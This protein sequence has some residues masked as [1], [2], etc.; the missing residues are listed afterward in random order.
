MKGIWPDGSRA[1]RRG[2][3]RRHWKCWRISWMGSGTWLVSKSPTEI[4]NLPT[5]FWRMESVRLVTLGS[6]RILIRDKTQLWGPLWARPFTCHLKSSLGRST[7]TNQISG[8]LDWS[9]MSCC[10]GTLLGLQRTKFNW[11]TTLWVSQSSSTAWSLRKV[12]TLSEA[13][14]RSRRIRE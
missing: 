5:S 14:W 3:R 6:L 1:K 11:L 9:T 4:W 8:L 12:R 10:T 13:A 2:L 7:L